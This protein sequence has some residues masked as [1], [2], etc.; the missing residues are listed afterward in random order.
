MRRNF[1]LSAGLIL[2]ARAA[3]TPCLNRW[4]CHARKPESVIHIHGQANSRNETRDHPS[5]WRGEPVV[6][7]SRPPTQNKRVKSAPS[8][9][10]R[11]IAPGEGGGV[12]RGSHSRTTKSRPPTS[13]S[14][15]I[16]PVKAN[17]GNGRNGGGVTGQ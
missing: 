5:Q 3:D 9:P 1:K 15:I 13:F 14:L 7:E 6:I 10:A 17:E 12:P 11:D 16:L 2:I 8:G 4:P